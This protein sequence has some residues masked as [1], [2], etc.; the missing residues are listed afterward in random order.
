MSINEPESSNSSSL[1]D[2]D[3][4][5]HSNVDIV[6]QPEQ[7]RKLLNQAIIKGLNLDTKEKIEL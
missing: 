5:F 3:F 4:S 2:E 6:D 7:I 1:S